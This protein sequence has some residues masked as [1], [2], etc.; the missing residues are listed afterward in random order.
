[1]DETIKKKIFYLFLAI[2]AALWTLLQCLRDVMSIDAMEAIS[3]GELISFGT[4]KHPPLTGWLAAPIYNFTGHNDI[5][6]YILGQICVL[7]GFVYIYK[8]AKN[9][10]SEDKAICAVLILE[11]CYYYNYNIFIDNFNCNIILLALWPLIAYY[12]YESVKNDK[13]KDWI[14]FGIFSGLAFLGKYQIAFFLFALFI[15]LIISDRKQFFCKGLWIAVA[16]GFLIIIPHLIWVYNHDFFCLTY[17][18]NRAESDAVDISLM[19]SILNRI[20][21]PVKFYADQILAI[22]GCIGMYLITV[23]QTKNKIRINDNENTN[24]KIFLLSIFLVPIIS[25]GLLGIIT[26]DRV[27]GIWGSTMAGYTGLILF[28]FFPFEFKQ[29]T[30]KFFIKLSTVVMVGFG[31]AIFLFWTVQTKRYISIPIKQITTDINSEW[32]K[33]TNGAPLKYVG[34][35]L[36]YS[37]VYRYYNPEKPHTVL[38]TFGYKNPWENHKDILK[39]G[40]LVIVNEPEDLDILTKEV[41]TLLPEDY[42]IK[43]KEYNYKICNKFNVCEDDTLYYT[44]I[45]PQEINR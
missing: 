39:S 3:W 19:Q 2:N 15:Y 12:F 27:P 30:F 35:N 26:G 5:S 44:I 10:I 29:D 16:T 24:D 32:T 14:L 21:Y 36:R 37:F 31:L 7:V 1:M 41:I 42:Q 33:E 18:I 25:L 9:F 13:L 6:I 11:S 43:Q 28:Y 8:L 40:A 23:L 45:P 4:N 34:G 20:F 22:L 38:E 17:M